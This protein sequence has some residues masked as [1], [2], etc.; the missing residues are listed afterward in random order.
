MN[1]QDRHSLFSELIRRHQSE[2]YAYI[3][4]VVRNWEDADDL[5]QSVCLV[6]WSKF[7]SFRVNS[8]FFAWARR[9]ARITVCNFL[10]HKQLERYASEELLTALTETEI[11]PRGDDSEFY[12]AALRRCKEKL[13]ATD[14]ELLK[15]R[16]VEDLGS[17]QLADRLHR[18]Q[19]S[20]S[21]SLARVQRWL[22][23]CIQLEL[24]RREHSRSEHS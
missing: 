20:V 8:S 16:Y 2:I 5:F 3:F 15:L 10:R 6:L 1:V 22:F 18:P 11:P 21:N 24:V 7:E 23:E 9:T 17:R 13:S 4:S 14:E 12:L 19:R